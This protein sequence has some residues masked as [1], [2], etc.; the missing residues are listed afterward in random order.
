[1]TPL[2]LALSLSNSVAT[3][4]CTLPGPGSYSVQTGSTLYAWRVVASGHVDRK[5]H[6]SAKLPAGGQWGFYR[7]TFTAD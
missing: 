5:S 1:M 6:L 7:V 2:I 4:R 3:V